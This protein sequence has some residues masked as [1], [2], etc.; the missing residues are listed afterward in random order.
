[1]VHRVFAL[2]EKIAILLSD[3]NDNDDIKFILE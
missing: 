1:V 2:K 3:K